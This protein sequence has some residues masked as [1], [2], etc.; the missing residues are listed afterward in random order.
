[1]WMRDETPRVR[2]MVRARFAWS[3][4]L[5]AAGPLL[6][7]L[8]AQQGAAFFP[9]YRVLT[10]RV[11]AALATLTS[12]APVAVWDLGIL[13]LLVVSLLRLIVR[14]RGR[15]SILPVLSHLALVASLTVF[16]WVAWALNHYAPPLA[17]DLELSV[18]TY[19]ID[20]LADATEWYLLQA[21]ELATR[22]PRDED[23]A[24]EPQ[25]FFELA[26]VAGGSY[27]ELGKRYEVLRGPS[28]P[29]KA[30]LVWGE[31]LLYSG[32]TGIFWAPAGESCVPIHCA[33]ADK[34]FIM[35]HEAAHRMCIASEQ[36]A[37][38][39]AYLACEASDDVR[40]S[41]SGAYN[42]FSYC[43][44]ALAA[45]DSDRAARLVQNAA[46]SELG[47]GVVLVW[48]DRDSTSEHYD[49][50]KG[51]FEKVG[52]DVNDHYLKSFGEDEG[53][54]SYGL[55]V[56]YLIAWAKKGQS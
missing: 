8:F 6:M 26:H 30:L 22:V 53:V 15:R 55:V 50:Y 9:G 48:G 56:D 52:S 5:F 1:M 37:N 44:N 23:G 10:K 39:A 34:P 45:L 13:A 12:V 42:A 46:D 43:F 41:Y 38:F 3:I 18:G 32:H 31:P 21:A 25:D 47:E 28:V 36:E 20:E 51:T 54:R 35:C 11:M 7:R 17:Q 33:D 14:I 24:L 49:A 16:F 19:S 4:V 40:F 27:T 29:V 2:R